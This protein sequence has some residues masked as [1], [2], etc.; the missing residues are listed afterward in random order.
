MQGWAIVLAGPG[1]AELPANA[2][3]DVVDVC[4]SHTDCVCPRVACELIYL[5]QGPADSETAWG[6]RFGTLI[7]P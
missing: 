5:T 6:R 1:T 2:R 7:H 4:C 3:T